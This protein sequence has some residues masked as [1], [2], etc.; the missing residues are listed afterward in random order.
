MKTLRKIDM[1][2][3]PLIFS[4]IAGIILRTFALFTSFNS[5]TMHYDDKTAIGFAIGIIVVS[6]I[7]FM[8][9]LFFGEK[10]GQTS[11][12][13]KSDSGESFEFTITVRNSANGNGWL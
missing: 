3:I 6:V 7:G 1:Y 5:Q 8:S 11:A 13:I 4:A 2:I 12:V 9:Y 10:E